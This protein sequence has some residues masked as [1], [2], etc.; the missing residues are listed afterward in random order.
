M[1]ATVF[2]FT[3]CYSIVCYRFSFV[4]GGDALPTGLISKRLGL[5]VS[6]DDCKMRTATSGLLK[7]GAARS[8]QN[9]GKF[10]SYTP[11]QAGVVQRV[12]NCQV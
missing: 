10:T 4:Q 12:M 2:Q 9:S 5:S 3:V 8:S 7:H 11:E 1:I 6:W